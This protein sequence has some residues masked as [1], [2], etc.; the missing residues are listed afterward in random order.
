M[1][2]ALRIVLGLLGLLFVWIG[3]GFLTFPQVSGGDFGLEAIGNRGLSSIRADFTAFFCVSGGALIL[4]A[5]RRN[6]GML[7]VTAALMGITLAGRA[8]SLALD[9]PYDGWLAPMT[10]E[11][12]AVALALLGSRALP[13]KPAAPEQDAAVFN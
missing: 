11:A 6:G 12:V 5:W 2:I 1:I 7:L 4:G 13:E 9:G 8:V 3:L 10:V